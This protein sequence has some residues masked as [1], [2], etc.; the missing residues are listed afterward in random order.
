MFVIQYTEMEVLSL[1]AS[2]TSAR[3]ILRNMQS[4]PKYWEDTS[5][6]RQVALV[7]GLEKLC[8]TFPKD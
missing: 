8:S 2:L 1:R 7:S 3:L 6:A 4:A 5:I